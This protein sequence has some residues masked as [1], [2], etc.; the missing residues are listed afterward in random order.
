MELPKRKP[1][2][3]K[4]Y[5][6]SSPGTYFITIC[7]K[8]RKEL[9]SKIIVGTGVLDCPKNILT[10]YGEIANKHIQ[11]MSDFYDNIKIDKFVIM[12]NHIHLLIQISEIDNQNG[13][14][15][16]PVPTNSFIAQ[17]VSTFKRFCNREYGENIWQA[18][19]NDH[20]IRNKNDYKK[21]WE[22]IDTNVRRW[23]KDCFYNNERS[24]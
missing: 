7:V 19:S 11:D 12:P 10:K 21:I 3:L 15:G 23:E 24:Q 9:L 14:S 20:I 8:D 1:T 6:Y 4:G 18:R 5:D 17:F 16:T 22:Y 2:R 13:P